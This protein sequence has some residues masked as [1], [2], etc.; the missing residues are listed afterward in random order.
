MD[1]KLFGLSMLLLFVLDLPWLLFSS[2]FVK[3]M[4]YAIQNQALQIRILPAALVY[5]ALAYLVNIAATPTDAFWLGAAT[6]AVYDLTN[7]A[8]LKAYSPWFAVADTL[9][10][11]LLMALVRYVLN[12]LTAA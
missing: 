7:L 8:T 6:Y 3:P 1:L 12:Y 2:T 5:V 10:G 9:W 11:G 4:I